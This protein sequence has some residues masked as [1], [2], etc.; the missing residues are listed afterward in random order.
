MRL[1]RLYCRNHLDCWVLYSLGLAF[2]SYLTNAI[3]NGIDVS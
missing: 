3:V 1:L 2:Q